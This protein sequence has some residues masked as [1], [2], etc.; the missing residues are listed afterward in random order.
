MNDQYIGVL[1]VAM[2]GANY[3]KN[4]F[5]RATKFIAGNPVYFVSRQSHWQPGGSS[6]FLS[7]P[8]RIGSRIGR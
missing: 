5:A 3:R 7:S 2:R 1:L 8:V 4:K 6:S